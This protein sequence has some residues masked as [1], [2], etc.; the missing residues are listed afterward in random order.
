M[1][2]AI[3]LCLRLCLSLTFIASLSLT[4]PCLCVSRTSRSLFLLSMT[5]PSHLST[6]PSIHPSIRLSFSVCLPLSPLP[7]SCHVVGTD[8]RRHPRPEAV[9]SSWLRP[10]AETETGLVLHRDSLRNVRMLVRFAPSD[11]KV[12]RLSS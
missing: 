5:P 1:A 12:L 6:Y 8:S 2:R 7:S 4:F 9:G 11:F 3:T 10:G